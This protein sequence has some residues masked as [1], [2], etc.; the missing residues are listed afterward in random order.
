M[1]NKSENKKRIKNLERAAQSSPDNKGIKIVWDGI[2]PGSLK[3]PSDDGKPG[4]WLIEWGLDGEIIKRRRGTEEQEEQRKVDQ[5]NE[6]MAR[7]G[8]E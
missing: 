4:D 5:W 8:N 3:D 1:E 6:L 7:R 2:E